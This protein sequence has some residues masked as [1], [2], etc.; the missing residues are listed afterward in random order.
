MALVSAE[1]AISPRAAEA[2]FKVHR[3][4]LYKAA[5]RGQLTLISFGGR[6]WFDEAEIAA[7]LHEQE[8]RKS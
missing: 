8:R 1:T 4:R 6:E 5:A 2:R 3:E 7:W